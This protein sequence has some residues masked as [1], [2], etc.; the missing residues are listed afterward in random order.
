MATTLATEA[1]A[2]GPMTPVLHRVVSS[3]RE[4]A[5]TW[6]LELESLAAP[7][8]IAPGQF[9]MLYAF[10]VGE[11]PISVSSVSELDGP[12]V[13]TIRNVGAVTAALCASRAGDVIGVR[14]PFG[15]TWPLDEAV[16]GDLLIV[17]GGIGLAP[18]RPAM[19][20]ALAHRARFGD[21][22][23][24]VGARNPAELLYPAELEEWRGRFDVDVRVTVDTAVG[25]WHGRV[26][27]VTRLIPHAD[28]DPQTATVLLCGPEAMIRF[29]AYALLDAGVAPERIWVSQE[30]NMQCGVGHCG[31]CQL[32][33]F[34]L[35]RDGP[36]LRYDLVAPLLEVREL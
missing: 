32:G 31:H 10:G 18:L 4:T 20:H 6:T 3:T 21:V 7:V 9:N 17:A 13:H 5:D 8:A 33:P 26:G 1:A 23:L 14:G 12:L 24:L 19:H 22:C 25:E 16:G 35:C 2:P 15:T 34:L 29:T 27:V 28:F 36:V 30:R 11:V